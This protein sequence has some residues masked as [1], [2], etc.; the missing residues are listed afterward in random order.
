MS[1]LVFLWSLDHPQTNF[2]TTNSIAFKLHPINQTVT[3][4]AARNWFRAPKRLQFVTFW[5]FL[6]LTEN[7]GGHRSKGID[8]IYGVQNWWSEWFSTWRTQTD[9]QIVRRAPDHMPSLAATIHD[10]PL[11]TA[12]YQGEI[13]LNSLLLRFKSR[14]T[15]QCSSISNN[16]GGGGGGGGGGGTGS[17]GVRVG[18][19]QC[20][21]ISIQFKIS[22]CC[23]QYNQKSISW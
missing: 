6:S 22:Y 15:L 4:R 2:R 16:W 19:I 13:N 20:N 14:L 3:N 10:L 8:H 7:A 5:K 12:K 11:T 1:Y 21:S 18:G 23:I 17:R 9:R